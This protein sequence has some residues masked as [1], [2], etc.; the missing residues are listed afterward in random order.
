MVPAIDVHFM[1][2]G[3]NDRV[4]TS[5]RAKRRNEDRRLFVHWPGLIWKVYRRS[6][7]LENVVEGAVVVLAKHN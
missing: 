5:G 1:K 6:E 3:G 4:L 7:F 2:F